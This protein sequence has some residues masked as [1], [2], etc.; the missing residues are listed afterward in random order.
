[1][2]LRDDF[3]PPWSA[4]NPWEGFHCAWVNTMVRH[5]NGCC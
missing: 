2:P 3:H 5:L 1:M 4:Q